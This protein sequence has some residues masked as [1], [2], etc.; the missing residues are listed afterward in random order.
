VIRRG[1]VDVSFG[2]LHYAEAGQG[3]PIV[4]LH[5]TPRSWDEYREVIPLLAGSNRVIAFDT[6]GY[7]NSDTPPAI[8]IEAF[9]DAAAEAC[10]ALGLGPACV[11][12]HHT[13]GVIA[14][15]M[16]ARHPGVVERLVL[17]ST[18]FVDAAARERRSSRPPIDDVERTDDGSFL[19][20]LW[21]CRSSFYPPGEPEL[22]ERFVLDALRNLDLAEEGHRAVSRYRMEDTVGMI[23]QPVLLIGA[24]KDPYAFGELVHFRARFPEASV[25]VVEEGMVPLM[26]RQPDEVA[27]H[28]LEFVGASR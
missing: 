1:Y 23:R 18:P 8:S 26:E 5:Q 3:A 9:A 27:S 21:N 22:K 14:I 25:A 28:I 16:A 17:S 24:A 10:A 19:V 20:D 12:G 11:V 6:A 4:L 15:D 7:G 2:Q 13:G